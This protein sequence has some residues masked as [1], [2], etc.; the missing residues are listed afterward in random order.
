MKLILNPLLKFIS[1]IKKHVSDTEILFVA[2]GN[3]FALTR[4]IAR[5]DYII[6]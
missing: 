3:F 4:G 2:F 5:A 6:I 1:L